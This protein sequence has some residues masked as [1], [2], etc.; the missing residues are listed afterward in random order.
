MLRRVLMAVLV[1]AAA[2]AAVAPTARASIVERVVAVVGERP[3]FWTELLRRAKPSRI[4]IRMQTGD[5]NVVSVQEQEMYKELLEKMI[6]ERLEEQQADKAHISVSPE[7][8]DRAIANIAAQ[9]QQ[10]QGRPVTPQDVLGEVRRR[11]SSE[12][13]FREELRWQ[14]LEAKLVELRVRPRVR[15]TEQ[16]ARAA[17]QHW[18]QELKQQQPVDVRIIALRVN[19]P[20]AQVAQAK[21]A[22][23]QQVVN[24]ARQGT[25]FCKLVATYSDDVG[26]RPTCGS[27][28]PQPFASLHPPIQEAIKT[29]KPGTVSDPI[30][31]QIGQEEVIVVVMPMGQS[32][33]PPYEQ[34][35]N[36]MMQRATGDA[37]IRGQ[38]QWL[39][40]LRQNVYID[41]RL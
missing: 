6:D 23:A 34:V 38:K 31:L 26:T 24:E 21:L 11:G 27:H 2:L 17:Y 33:A 40:E 35:K 19:P 37:L 15:V 39:Q 8:I 14:V 22:L 16:D 9:A 3:V 25:D 12:Q 7:E 1:G 32:T 36:E 28:G 10:S 4:Q 29:L 13:D 41:V 20:T 30:P 5:P 18:A